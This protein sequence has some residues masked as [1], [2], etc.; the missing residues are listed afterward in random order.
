[1]TDPREQRG[2]A[3]LLGTLRC[4]SEH[5]PLS[6]RPRA[7][8]PIRAGRHGR[9]TVVRRAPPA[10]AAAVRRSPSP[11]TMDTKTDGRNKL[12]CWARAQ[13]G[14]ESNPPIH[15]YVNE[16]GWA[17]RVCAY[18]TAPAAPRRWKAP[19]RGPLLDKRIPGH[20]LTMEDDATGTAATGVQTNPAASHTKEP[21]SRAS[22]AGSCDVLESGNANQR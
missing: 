17:N 10:L 22:Q 16:I 13:R 2:W 3:D 7:W 6:R 11:H 20:N 8:R 5:V 9:A 4:A 14:R 1:V 12:A 18:R 15:S 21:R 19:L